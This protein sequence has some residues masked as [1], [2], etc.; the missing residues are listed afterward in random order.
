MAENK[1]DQQ[2]KADAGIASQGENQQL[3]HSRGGVTT[4]DDLL[5]AGVP[6]LQGDPRERQG[7]EDALGPGPKRGDYA[8]RVGPSSYHP[9]TTEPIPE[10][11]RVEGGPTVRLVPQRPRAEEQG[12]VPRKKGGVETDEESR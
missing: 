9:H 6:M 7:P 4:R 3:D 2:A 10:D 8:A 1:K 5:D 12:E 11:E